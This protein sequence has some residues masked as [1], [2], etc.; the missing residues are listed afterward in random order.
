[1]TCSKKLF[2]VA[3]LLNFGAA[4][5]NYGLIELMGKGGMPS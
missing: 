3:L 1:M 2:E 5:V 4:R